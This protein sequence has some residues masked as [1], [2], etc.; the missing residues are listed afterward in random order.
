[1]AL[2][3]EHPELAVR[4]LTIGMV[5]GET[6][7]DLLGA[8][9]IK[10]LRELR[11]KLRFTGIGGPRMEAVGM[12][13]LFPLEKL[14]VRG[15]IEV[16]QH[17]P[18]ILSIRRRLRRHFLAQPPAA[19]VG[20]DAPDFNLQLELDLK[21]R[22]IPTIHYVSPQIWMWRKDRMS[23]IKRAVS[24]MLTLFPFEL[25][26]Y[27]QAGVDAAFVG[28]PLA[29]LLK[30]IPPRAEL[31][32]QLKLP[33][34]PTVVALLPGSRQ[35]EIE[36]LADVFIQTAWKI[37]QRMPEAVLQVPLATRETRTQFE[38]ILYRHSW[39]YEFPLTIMFGHAHDAMAAADVVLLAS[40]TATLEAALLKLPMVIA[41]RMPALSHWWLSGKG[42]LPY[43]GL[44]NILCGEFVVP[45]F[46]QDDATSDNLTQAVVNLLSDDTVRSRLEHKFSMLSTS[47]Q[48]G[49]AQRAAEAVLP[50]ING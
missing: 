18:K 2:S 3:A 10:A 20:I 35:S 22:G 21:A 13:V 11:P 34:T 39:A 47:L 1:V 31:R 43:Y 25:P 8:E 28:H 45:E 12:E 9:L 36:H 50:L 42:Y 14:A 4:N 26:L 23:E 37:H 32:E 16:L 17:L 38:K 41:Y 27:E 46:I 7:G 29:D 24:K 33:A 44:P 15:Y 40:G 6:S 19:F 5:A 48:L 30:K 49:A